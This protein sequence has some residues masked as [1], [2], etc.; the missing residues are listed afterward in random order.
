MTNQN[1]T[2]Q[3]HDSAAVKKAEAITHTIA[4]RGLYIGLGTIFL[5]F[6]AL[7]FSAY[8]A[9]AIAGLIANSPFVS[10]FQSFLSERALSGTIGTI[11]LA[12]GALLFGRF[13]SPKLS[14]IGAAGA[15]ATFLLTFSF[16]FTTPGVFLPEE[17]ALIISVLPGQFLVK[18]LGL[19][20]ASVVVLSESVRAIR[21][22]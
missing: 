10:F 17:G 7:K 16:F 13:I 6:G 19:L 3:L 8:E 11:E 2:A 9:G 12:V 18:D 5:V 4:D 15:I 21:Q 22:K 1:L 14:A 20:L